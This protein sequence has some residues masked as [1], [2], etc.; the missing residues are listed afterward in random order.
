MN[1]LNRIA[2]FAAGVAAAGAQLSFAATGDWTAV[3]GD[4][5]QSKYSALKQITTANVAGI[6]KAWTFPA[7]GGSLTPVAV[8]GVVY[9]PSGNKVFAIEG[10]TGK[11]IW[12][13][14]LSTLIPIQKG[15]D[16]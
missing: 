1:H 13:T 11:Q 12:E 14:D 8:N 4:V 2:T 7:G 16:L 3:F 9:Y 5:T 6:A 10:D 15:D